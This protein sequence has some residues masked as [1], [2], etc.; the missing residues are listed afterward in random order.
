[1]KTKTVVFFTA[2][3]ILSIF[4]YDSDFSLEYL[5]RTS[6]ISLTGESDRKS[7]V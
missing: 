7:V 3:F 6:L 1:M 5:P 4:F 2:L